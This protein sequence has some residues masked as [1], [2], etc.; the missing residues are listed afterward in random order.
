MTAS[1]RA[2]ASSF[3]NFHSDFLALF[4]TISRQLVYAFR[5]IPAHQ[6]ED[7]IQEGLATAFLL[8]R[9]LVQSDNATRP[10]ATPLARFAIC[11]IRDNRT[12][13]VRR[14][15]HDAACRIAANRHGFRIVS[16]DRFERR[17]ACWSSL[18]VFSNQTSVPDQVA[19][20]LDFRQWLDNQSSRNR[21]IVE[22]LASGD[23]PSEAAS[24]FR[25]SRGR[26]SQLRRQFFDSWT[27]FQGDGSQ[28]QLTAAVA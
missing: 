12:L 24:R 23:S 6:R 1:A 5:P 13:G 22:A 9:R 19:F 15:P 10:S 28:P 16:L 14:S 3:V 2:S 7:L 25:I 26:I 17:A 8:F 18:P 21:L 4:P 11:R 27:A 20:R